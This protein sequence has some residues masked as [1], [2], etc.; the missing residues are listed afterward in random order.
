MKYTL[1]TKKAMQIAYNAHHGQFDYNGVPYIYHPIHLA[2]QMDD[3]ICCAAAL[4]HDVVEDTEITLDEL[5]KE[6]PEEIIRIVS[7]LTHDENEDYFDYIKRIKD[8][9]AA[10]K[11]KLADLEHNSDQSRS[12]GSDLSP[13][14]MEYWK[15]K[16]Q[17]ARDILY[18]G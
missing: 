16:Y 18:E 12:I 3:E 5:S 9:P 2:E 17:R 11:I 14:R 6:F 8:H 1:L 10:R 13:E 7:L 15:E 4:L